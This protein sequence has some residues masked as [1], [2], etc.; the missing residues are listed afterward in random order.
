M[1]A[2]FA[3][4]AT[5]RR[6]HHRSLRYSSLKAVARLIEYHD[7]AL[8]ANDENMKMLRRRLIQAG[9]Y[10]P[11]AIAYFF[12]RANDSC[13]RSCGGS[14]FVTAIHYQRAGSLLLADGDCRRHRRLHWTNPIH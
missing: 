3:K 5:R 9:V 12:H 10:D 1:R 4:E 11:R 14:L 6:R 8:H 13:R 2:E 7:E